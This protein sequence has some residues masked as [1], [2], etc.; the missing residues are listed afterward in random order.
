VDRGFTFKKLV[1]VVVEIKPVFFEH[2][3]HERK[4]GVGD[5]CEGILAHKKIKV[6]S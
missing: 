4:G 3:S 5:F 6:I 2:L 1:F